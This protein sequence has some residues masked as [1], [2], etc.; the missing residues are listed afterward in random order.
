MSDFIDHSRVNQLEIDDAYAD[1][2]IDNYLSRVLKGVPKSLIYKIIRKGEV[3]INKKRVKPTYRLQAGDIIRI[4]PVRVKQIEKEVSVSPNLKEILENSVLLEDENCLII[5][6]PAGMAVHGGSGLN[7]GVIEAFR[8]IRPYAKH[9][10]LVHRLDRETSGCLILAK[11]RSF[12]KEC[13]ELIRQGKVFKQYLALVHGKWPK[14][15]K[16]LDFPL[17]KNVLSSGERIV[18]VSPDGKTALT[19]VRIAKR[20]KEATLLEI[21]LHTGRTHQIR[22]HTAHAGHP[23]IGDIKYGDNAINKSLQEV[24]P[25]RMFLHA[26]YVEFKLSDGVAA[27]KVT[28]PPPNDFQ[29]AQKKLGQQS[30]KKIIKD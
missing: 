4:P 8:E 21:Q 7:F 14:Y 9:L 15:L 10:E 18:K 12:L 26:S 27:I 2:R 19:T 1:Q 11:N 13:H 22:V 30:I 3:R 6:K 17:K 29:T 24:I 25:K 28:A 23:I 16:E 5:N 20:Y